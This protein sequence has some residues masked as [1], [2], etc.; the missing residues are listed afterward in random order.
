MK[1]LQFLFIL[2]LIS[3]TVFA[4]ISKVETFLKSQPNVKSVEVIPGNSFFNATYKIMF[5]QPLDHS[6]TTKGFFLQRI[7]LGDRGK[8]N[9][10]LL[11]TEGYD[12]NRAESPSFI[13]ELSPMLNSNQIFVEHRY[14]GESWPDSV[15][16]DYLT[17]ANV[18]ED[19]HAVV[20]LFKKYY[21]AK[22]VNTGIS[23]GGQTAV[24]H[25]FFFPG[26]VDATVAYVGPLN[27][28][29]EDGR[30]EPFINKKAG[31]AEQRKQILDFQLAVLRNRDKILPMLDKF[32][33]AGN[34]TFRISHDEVLDFCVLEYSFSIWQWGTYIN[35]IP[36]KNANAEV[37]FEHL[38]KVA[39]PS[40][41]SLEGMEAFK[42]FYVQA[43]RELG[44]YGY[45]TKPLKKYL[46]IKNAEGYLRYVFLPA[47]LEIKYEKETSQ[48]VK[49]FIQ[50]T[51]ARI[52]FIYGEYDPW[53]ASA[54][55]V[56]DKPNF[57]KIVKPGGSHSTRI[58]NLPAE[59]QVQ[60]KEKMESWLGIPFLIDK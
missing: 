1:K 17:V 58:K 25:R 35:Q 31:T 47:D 56:P 26:D 13:E 11:V 16:W 33:A 41:F 24:Y 21:T 55:N 43:A 34:Y 40:Y 5:R 45:D 7:L 2:F 37:L 30:H 29:V 18:A 38:M 15:N 20:E 39:D 57:L 8:D 28:G 48:E 59:Q 14:F 44:Y 19:H 32:I 53:S 6:D 49:K 42:S 9:T 10:S 60:I 51:D 46:T 22:W 4:R 12:A 3:S 27:F 54:F 50:E 52:L 36:S 23:K